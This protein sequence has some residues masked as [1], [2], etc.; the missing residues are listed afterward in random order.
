M[1]LV[2]NLCTGSS[3][4]LALFYMT[5]VTSICSYDEKRD[6]RRG[7]VHNVGSYEYV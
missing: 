6:V 5:A 2:D 3:H 1:I 4:L 7:D